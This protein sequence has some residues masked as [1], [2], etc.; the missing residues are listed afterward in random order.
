MRTSLV[1]LVG[2]GFEE[3]VAAR[4]R[5][6]EQ[7]FLADDGDAWSR[8][9]RPD[10][11][12]RLSALVSQVERASEKCGYTIGRRPVVGTLPTRDIN[13]QSVSGPPGEGDIIVF[14]TGLFSFTSNV[15]GVAAQ[16]L[17]VRSTADGRSMQFLG[18]TAAVNHIAR[19]PGIVVQ[20]IDLLF[21]QAV[22]GTSNFV[23][24]Y[25]PPP[26]N[27]PWRDRFMD[28]MDVFVLAH[29]YGHVIL[30]HTDMPRVHDRQDPI[31][32]QQLEFDA[33]RV[34]FDITSA[35]CYGP[36][37]AAVGS[38]LFLTASDIVARARA[39]YDSGVDALEAS[40]SHPSGAQRRA[41]LRPML[42]DKF[43]TESE[44]A[45]RLSDTVD[46]ILQ[47]FWAFA[48]PAFERARRGGYP[49]PGYQPRDESEKMAALHAFI[50]ESF[51]E[52]PG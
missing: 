32:V 14:E 52:F 16:A 35:A 41:A 6:L 38:T 34:A 26:P 10:H 29:E 21:S 45:D 27:A 43:A 37:F 17:D 39:S 36:V 12:K 3:A 1:N 51:P 49:P 24:M 15:A 7:F 30:G 8:Y 4:M 11:R 33:D 2:P 31:P 18:L 9:E 23:A 50:Q 28:A 42:H 47:R 46:A 48:Q 44:F 19:I 20:F 5:E 22:L 25:P 13:A 40:P